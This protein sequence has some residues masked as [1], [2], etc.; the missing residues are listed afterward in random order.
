MSKWLFD[1]LQEQG[2]TDNMHYIGF[3][4]NIVT[5]RVCNYHFIR[6]LYRGPYGSAR[7]TRPLSTADKLAVAVCL[8]EH[9]AK[10]LIYPSGSPT[11]L[12]QDAHFSPDDWEPVF[13]HILYNAVTTHLTDVRNETALPSFSWALDMFDTYLHDA[14][15]DPSSNYTNFTQH[16]HYS[17]FKPP[18]ANPIPSKVRS[19]FTHDAIEHAISLAMGRIKNTPACPPLLQ[20]LFTLSDAHFPPL[21]KPSYD[22]WLEW[23]IRT[24]N[25][26]VVRVTLARPCPFPMRVTQSQFLLGC[27][28]NTEVVRKLL[29][30]PRLSA[31]E[32]YRARSP[33]ML[34]LGRGTADVVR[35]V[36]EEGADVNA[37]R[38]RVALASRDVMKVKVC[39]SYH[40]VLRL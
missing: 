15:Q 24:G 16:L 40:A 35:A 26:D 18:N 19:F 39:G 25:G 5:S 28:E 1:G 2:I 30:S 7:V 34:A 31:D 11:S 38:K 10:K 6:Y 27:G 23:A 14:K 29:R 36:V 8:P 33:L 17:L 21:N 4:S 20:R 3:V 9:L 37:R 12:L 22:T 32:Y 13:G